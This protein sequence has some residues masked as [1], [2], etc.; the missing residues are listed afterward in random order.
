MAMARQKLTSLRFVRAGRVIH[1]STSDLIL[2]QSTAPKTWEVIVVENTLGAFYRSTTRV[3]NSWKQYDISE[4]LSIDPP[5]GL[6]PSWVEGEFS[7]ANTVNKF[8]AKRVVALAQAR[9]ARSAGGVAIPHTP[10][11]SASVGA[12]TLATPLPPP[13]FPGIT[14]EKKAIPAVEFKVPELNPN[15]YWYESREDAKFIRDFIAVRQAGHVA[16][17]MI[18]GPSGSGKTEGIRHLGPEVGIPVHIVNCQVITTPEK[19]L[20][21]MMADPARG[22][23]FEPSTHLQW[24]ERTHDDCKG[25]EHCILLYD[26]ITRLRPELNNMTYSLFDKQ[27]GLEVP[28]MGRRVMMAEGNIVIATANMGAAFVGTFGQ[29]RAFRERFSFTLERKFPPADEEIKIITSATGVSTG[30]ARRLVEIANDSRAAW[31]SQTL[32]QPISTRILLAWA[33]WVSGGYSIKDAADYTVMPMYSDDGG[34]ESDRARIRI[35]VTGK[36]A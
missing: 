13:A 15:P 17:L 14:H 30:D 23:Y 10:V 26:E 34:V 35:M 2:V 3:S 25:S 16:N 1:R 5:P 36:G 24:V 20:G 19:W 11:P 33:M 6:I 29:D 18:A 9:A 4:Q 8:R 22:T 21:Q 32:D 27:Q 31:Q 12:P 7:S 28:Q